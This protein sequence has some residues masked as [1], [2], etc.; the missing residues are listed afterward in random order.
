MNGLH[1]AILTP[2]FAVDEA[3]TNCVPALQDFLLA[4]RRQHPPIALTVFT[5]RYP[6][7]KRRYNWH[8]I[9]VVPANGRQLR[10]PLSLMSWTRL[11]S[12]FVGVMRRTP[13]GIVHSFWLGECA[14]L[15]ERLS[16]LYGL[17]HV[18]TMMGQEVAVPNR[19]AGLLKSQR[20]TFVAVSE[21]QRQELLKFT[22]HDANHVIPWGLDAT[23]QNHS[24][25]RDIDVIGVGSLSDVKDFAT[26]LNVIALLREVKP[27]LRCHIAGDGP[28]RPALEAQ[29]KQ[30][31]LA[32]NVTFDGRV[33]RERVFELMRRSRVLLHTS[34]F[35]LFGLVFAEALACGARIVSRGVGIAEGGPN[36]AVCETPAEMA[37]CTSEF[38]ALPALM[39]EH[40]DTLSGTVRAYHALYGTLVDPVLSAERAKASGQTA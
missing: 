3:D 37:A 35:E 8:G 26:F 7:T 6:H 19:H 22:G 9:A 20:T 17:P 40:P 13:I 2:G 36:W 1:I 18:V 11:A 29:A 27:T 21:F 24:G 38:L 15:G 14:F 34:R 32:A 4:L 16:G 30:L 31:G 25:T 10:F 28:L 39:P 12:S 33:S 5:L 23:N